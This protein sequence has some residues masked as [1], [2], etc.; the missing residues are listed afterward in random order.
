MLLEARSPSC[1]SRQF[2]LKLDDRAVGEFQGRWFSEG[3]DI[4]LT[5]RLK[6]HF[7]KSSWL[8][9]DFRLLDANSSESLASGKRTSWFSGTW[10]FSL[11]SGPAQFVR[12]GLFSTTFY[13]RRNGQNVAT[14]RRIGWC[15][16][17]W[18]V[19]CDDSLDATDLVFVGLVYHTILE[20]QRRNNNSS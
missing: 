7:E 18:R 16:R 15:E 8:G 11:Q 20:R 6:L 13:V 1:F 3:I 2:V 19:E 4:R 14:A 10:D 12:S 9:S 17:G 5:E